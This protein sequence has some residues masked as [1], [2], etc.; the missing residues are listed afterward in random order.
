MALP[1]ITR[2]R[3]AVM[4]SA[5]YPSKAVI[6]C[7]AR[8]SLIGGYT[9]WSDPRTSK[10]LFL[11]IAASVAM[12]VPHMPIRWIRLGNS[13]LL[14]Y[15]RRLRPADDAGPDAERQRHAGAIGVARWQAEEDGPPE[16][17]HQIGH[18]RFDGGPSLR[19]LVASRQLAEDDGG[20]A[21]EQP[22]Q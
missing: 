5:L 6:F 7:S 13:R 3:S 17:R 14:D 8:K 9:F 20:R 15:Q 11:S 10:P 18:D 16:V 12:A 4:W 19:R 1:T 22:R 21:R 2:S